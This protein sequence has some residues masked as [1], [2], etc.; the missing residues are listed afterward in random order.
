MPNILDSIQVSGASYD[1]KDKNAPSVSAVTQQEYDNL[2][3]SAKTSN[4][5]FVITDAEAG[6]LTN[7]YTKSET[8]TLLSGKQDTLISGTNIKTI[9]NESILGS[10][11]IDIQGGGVNVVQTTGTSITDVMSQ[12]AVTT[13]LNNK[14]NKSAAV[15][16]YRFGT[17][18]NVDYLRYRNVSNNDIG[19]EI[20]YPKINGKGILTNNG[21]WAKNNYNFQ[22]V[23]T[24]AIT[25]SVTSSSTD[26]QIPSAK[27]VYDAIQEGGGGGGTVDQTIISGSTNAVAGGAVYD[28]IDEVEQV[29]AA[30]LNALNGALGGLK[31]VKLTQA[32]YNALSTKDSSTLYVIVN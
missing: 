26:S 9:N 29:T 13:Q 19:S 24:S 30:G 5:F 10:G 21:T 25:T 12:D 1:I 15:G 23:E 22:L 20:Y 18:N 4:T 17:T 31:L 3:S 6:D 32:E 8:N 28:K 14:A 2:P 7:Y 16:G 11:N 27:A